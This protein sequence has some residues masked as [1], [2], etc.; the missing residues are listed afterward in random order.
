M[1][2]ARKKKSQCHRCVPNKL[3]KKTKPPRIT[4][5]DHITLLQSALIKSG[6]ITLI[7]KGSRAF[8]DGRL[9]SM[10][11]EAVVI[12]RIREVL[13]HDAIVQ[14]PSARSWHDISIKWPEISVPY[15]FNIK[16]SNGGQDNA[17]NKKAL[18]WSFSSMLESDIPNAMTINTMHDLIFNNGRVHGRGRTMR[19]PGNSGEY[20]YLY[21]DKRDS[22]VIIKSLCDI[23]SWVSNPQN[24]L[25]I[26]W[27]KEKA[28]AAT[29]NGR[30][31]APIRTRILKI[32]CTSL[33]HYFASCDQLIK[34]SQL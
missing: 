2:A 23:Q 5:F 10:H 32:I 3:R 20:F 33:N 21:V 19:S 13:S 1:T 9:N 25:Q 11:A 29:K 8:T 14:I 17:F 24:I 6:P 15:Y 34:S 30:L 16:V 26:N 4:S 27:T 28:R 22:T 12:K 7:K 31:I 18:V